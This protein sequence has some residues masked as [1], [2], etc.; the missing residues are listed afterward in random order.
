[1]VTGIADFR[2]GFGN[3][4]PGLSIVYVAEATSGLIAAYAAPWA[5]QLQTAG[6]PQS[7]N[8]VLLDKRKFRNVAIRDE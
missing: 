1:M 7:G 8:M 6:R 2:R 3:I 4:Q 5:P